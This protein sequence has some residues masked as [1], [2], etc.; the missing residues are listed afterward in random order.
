MAPRVDRPGR[1]SFPAR[2]ELAGPTR[3]GRHGDRSATWKDTEI[4]RTSGPVVPVTL[5]GSRCMPPGDRN[6]VRTVRH[7]LGGR[8][9]Q[10]VRALP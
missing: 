8:L 9:A 4:V 1:S 3:K 6:V 2:W 7:R 10:L 5:Q